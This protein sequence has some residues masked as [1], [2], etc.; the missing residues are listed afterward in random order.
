MRE[1]NK[2][3]WRKKAAEKSTCLAETKDMQEDISKK[4]KNKI[5]QK[6]NQT[7]CSRSSLP[8]GGLLPKFSSRLKMRSPRSHVSRTIPRR[9]RP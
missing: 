6:G 8:E 1:G 3:K 4:S 5:K 9:V 2:G 7:R